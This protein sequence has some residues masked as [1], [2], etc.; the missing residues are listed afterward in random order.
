[1]IR[2]IIK[3]VL[4]D[5]SRSLFP[6]LIVAAGSM[7]TVFFY[8][9][10]QGGKNNF[11]DTSA[12]FQTGHLK[13]MTRAY[14][15]ESD[16]LPNDLALT[17]VTALLDRLRAKYPELLWKP[18]IRF[19]GLLDVPDQTGETRAQGPVSG[20]AVELFSQTGSPQ[21][22]Q[23]FLDEERGADRDKR[24]NLRTKSSPL[25]TAQLSGKEE[26][27]GPDL[28]PSGP[29]TKSNLSGVGFHQPGNEQQGQTENSLKNRPAAAKASA[30]R[31]NRARAGQDQSEAEIL[32]L[33][34]GLVAGRLPQQP[35]EILVPIVLAESLKIKP[36]DRVTIISSTMSG[37]L[38]I[39][40]FTVAGIVRFG[41]TPLDKGLVIAD[42]ADIQRYLDME[43]AAGEIF[44]F[45]PDFLFDAK[46]AAR[47][48]REFNLGAGSEENL[49]SNLTGK[50]REGGKSETAS[51][52][53]V[54]QNSVPAPA[55]AANAG[56]D[57]DL[58]FRP[59]MLTLGQ[60]GGLA[61]MISIYDTYAYVLVAVFVAVMSIVLW[62]A[63][64]MASL[65]RYG[66]I[67]LR[68]AMG[69]TRPHLY[70]SL[71]GESLIVGLLGSV[72]GTALG[73]A[74]AYYLQAYGINAEA[75]TRS[76]EMM[77]TNLIRARVTW[78]SYVIGFIPGLLATLLGTS[79][80]GL[81][82]FRRR[83]ATLMK[84]FET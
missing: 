40:D 64:L 28:L 48:A 38:A 4:R 5:R 47:M 76:S 46:K 80:A 11:I 36:G 42:L 69:E 26:A 24:D 1:M 8:S 33:E 55:S 84:E 29:S 39:A 10:M 31:R 13:V 62:N 66:E 9:Y 41:I 68:L 6:V 32:N 75:F 50:E 52:E 12:R 56:Q 61:D 18:R 21:D 35:G 65:R 37:A 16:L 23:S 82:V 81:G 51:Q 45:F 67:G 57:T 70:F 63:G 74:I 43:D 83:T 3:G 71:L 73:L 2:F 19:S 53:I 7:L 60:Q 22:R 58:D 79:I 15:A 72:L 17:E 44:G 25:E 34:K 14:A 77:M 54:S 20:L 78:V 59:V 27:D 49:T 30:G